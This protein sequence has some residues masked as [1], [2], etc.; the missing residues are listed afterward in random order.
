M[1]TSFEALKDLRGQGL[2][3][4]KSL[5]L[6]VKTSTW[7][8][9]RPVVLRV[10]VWFVSIYRLTLRKAVFIGSFHFPSRA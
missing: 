3:N 2:R 8:K 5:V 9:L 10:I 6:R 1:P 7:G 4:L